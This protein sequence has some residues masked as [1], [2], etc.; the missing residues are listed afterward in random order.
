[1]SQVRRL[2]GQRGA[3][4]D[5]SRFAINPVTSSGVSITSYIVFH[6]A[7]QERKSR[8]QRRLDDDT[9]G[10]YVNGTSGL[11]VEQGE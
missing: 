4:F 1:M 10:V 8:L 3:S 2:V 6:A 11:M 7:C 5:T 9:I